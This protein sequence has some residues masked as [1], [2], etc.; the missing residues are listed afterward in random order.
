MA[1][2]RTLGCVILNDSDIRI[3]VYVHEVDVL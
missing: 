2:W 1:G 3:V